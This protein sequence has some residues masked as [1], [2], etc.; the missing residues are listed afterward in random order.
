MLDA[1]ISE[2]APLLALT[3]TTLVGGAITWAAKRFSDWTK[4]QIEKRNIDLLKEAWETGIEAALIDIAEAGRDITRKE[5]LEIGEKH[6]R[7]SIAGTIEAMQ[8]P[9]EAFL[10][11][12]KRTVYRKM[13]EFA[14][15]ATVI[16]VVEDD[17]DFDDEYDEVAATR[18]EG[19]LN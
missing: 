9:F 1:V 12:G 4:V 6:V 17:D 18:G 5:L 15:A 14:G 2:V 11:I 3:L 7:V 16:N 10:N 8:P 13:Q 19:G